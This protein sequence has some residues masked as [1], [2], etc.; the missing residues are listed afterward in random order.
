PQHF[1]GHLAEA[2]LADRRLF[3]ALAAADRSIREKR[4]EDHVL[5]R[6]AVTQCVPRSTVGH[7]VEDFASGGFRLGGERAR[8]MRAIPFDHHDMSSGQNYFCSLSLN[9]SCTPMRATV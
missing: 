9:R 7:A 8:A 3:A 6:L 4:C 1:E 5:K 2:L